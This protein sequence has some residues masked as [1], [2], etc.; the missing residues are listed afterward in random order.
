[1]VNNMVD[2]M[3]VKKS[4]NLEG[5]DYMKMCEEDGALGGVGGGGKV[6]PVILMG[7]TPLL[8]M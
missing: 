5:L 4:G 8:S 7:V 1:M 2:V 6:R 3:Q